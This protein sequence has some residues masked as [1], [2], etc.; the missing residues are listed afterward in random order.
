MTDREVKE[1]FGK[2]IWDMTVKELIDFKLDK[3]WAD[4][5]D[6]NVEEGK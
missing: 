2:S 4:L 1:I 5:V 3:V 6:D